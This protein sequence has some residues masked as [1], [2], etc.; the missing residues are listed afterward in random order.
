MDYASNEQEKNLVDI[1]GSN[2]GVLIML[3][4][5]IGSGKTT[6]A[7]TIITNY[8]RMIEKTFA[9]PLKKIAQT[10][11]FTHGQVYGSQEQ[12]LELNSFWG[13]SGREFLQK[14]GTDVCRN[15]LPNAIVDMQFNGMT[16]WA[17]LMEKTILE[18]LGSFH[19]VVSDGRFDD[20][21]RLIKRY[22]GVVVRIVRNGSEKESRYVVANKP[23]SLQQLP[24]RGRVTLTELKLVSDHLPEKHLS[25]V[26][27]SDELVDYIIENNGTLDDLHNK[28]CEVISQIDE[29]NHYKIKNTPRH[30]RIIP[31]G[32]L[33]WGVMALL[34]MW[35][36]IAIQ[37]M[38]V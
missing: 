2:R 27:V 17:R 25:E 7:N 8:D 6:V 21:A 5:K 31:K 36:A 18:N 28:V 35:V 14:F 30:I 37:C 11:G 13:I 38:G 32:N 22:G 4:G 24:T 10:I 33:F 16:L 3:T 19:I 23:L 29:W 15:A 20:E 34:I 12:K 9:W 26:G 1:F